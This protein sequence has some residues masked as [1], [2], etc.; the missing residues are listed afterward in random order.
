MS[1]ILTGKSFIFISLILMSLTVTVNAG[2]DKNP[3]LSTKQSPANPTEKTCPKFLNHKIKKLHSSEIISLCDLYKPGATVLIVNTA[4]HCGFTKQ[5]A[6]L[7]KLH[8]KYMDK[9]LIVLGFP[10]NSFFQEEKSEEGSAR[11]CYKNYGV[12]FTMF[13][14]TDVRGGKAHP[15]FQHLKE[16]SKAPSWNFNKYLIH[17]DR[18]EHFGSK[19]KPENSTLEEGIIKTFQM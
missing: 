13:S 12:T 9:G 10:S 14:H 19:I 11:V 18:V 4:S 6:G 3:K 17:G 2:E 16:E 1:S 5:F 7:E 15:I 8:K